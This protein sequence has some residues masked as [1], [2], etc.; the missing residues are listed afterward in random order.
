[1]SWWL[2]RRG[3]DLK[4]PVTTLVSLS[5][6]LLYNCFFSLRSISEYLRR[7]EVDVVYENSIEAPQQLWLYTPQGTENGEGSIIIIIFNTNKYL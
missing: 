2:S 6:T 3:M 1:M 4:R 5:K 7:V